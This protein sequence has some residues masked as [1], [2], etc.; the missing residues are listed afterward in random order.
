MLLSVK[1]GEKGKEWMG[2]W[3]NLDLES[4][5][6]VRDVVGDKSEILR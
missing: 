1:T 4:V 3:G 2:G 5:L 6:R